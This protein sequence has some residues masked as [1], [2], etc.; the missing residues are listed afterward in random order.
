M[1]G[2]RREQAFNAESLLRVLRS[3]PIAGQYVVGFSGGADSTA[4]LHALTTIRHQLAG[5]I[6]AVHVNH[7]LHE[8]SDQWQAHCQGFCRQYNIPLTCL[9]IELSHDTGKGMEAEARSLRYKAIK[10]LLGKNSALLTAHHADDQAETLLLNL[11]RGSGVDGL[12]AMPESRPIGNGLLLRPLLGFTNEQL[13]QYLKRNRI[14]WIDDPSNQLLDQDRNFLRREI[15][16]QLEQRWPGVSRRLLLT[17]EAMAD[18]R[19]L[20]ERVADRYLDQLLIHPHV[21]NLSSELCDDRQLLRLVIRRWARK[22]GASP[23]PAYKLA[24]FTEQL[25][26]AD[27]QSRAEL[28]WD[29]W[30]VRFY[31]QR[32]WLSNDV[33]VDPCPCVNLPA[34][35]FEVYLGRDVGR[36]VF[37]KNHPA[38][39]EDGLS[40]PLQ[41]GG[42][43]EQWPGAPISIS[44][45]QNAVSGNIRHG[46][47]HKKIK[48]LLQAAGVPPWLRDC[49]P[50]CQVQGALMAVGDWCIE[51]SFEAGL[52]RHNI[53]M[54]WQPEH[55][56]LKFVAEEQRAGRNIGQH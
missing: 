39:H 56:L 38:H 53:V 45:R 40:S 4:L 3:L 8:D 9:Q 54:H 41:T 51:P 20:L 7:G 15:V 37:K 49:I 2:N 10:D 55:P 28:R 17:R 26:K 52:R 44:G 19:V 24:D 31:R 46:G 35:N 16:P 13:L 21:L 18:T 50:L 5:E 6:S 34:G 1:S 27:T 43:L 32:L 25:V 36:L 29:G 42:G 33:A 22:T 11:M 30:K 47:V 48:K 14:D 12:S 23:L